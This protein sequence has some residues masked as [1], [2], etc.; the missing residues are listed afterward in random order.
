MQHLKAMQKVLH[1]INAVK[2][3]RNTNLALTKL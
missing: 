2:Y 3:H 1:W